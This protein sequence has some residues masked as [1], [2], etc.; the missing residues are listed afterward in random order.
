MVRIFLSYRREDSSGHA[1]HLFE[2]LTSLYGR[3]AVFMDVATLQGGEPFADRIEQAIGQADVFLAL[4]GKRWLEA[5]DESGRRRLDVPE[6]YVRREVAAAL[7]RTMLTIPVRLDGAAMP[8]AEE[9]PPNLKGLTRLNAF[10]LGSAQWDHDLE[11]LLT[12]LPP[13]PRRWIGRFAFAASI[14]VVLLVLAAVLRGLIWPA[15]QPMSGSF[16]VAVLDFGERQSSQAAV[17]TSADGRWIAEQVYDRLRWLDTR[18]EEQGTLV[19]TV[20]VVRLKEHV[21]GR[22]SAEI[23]RSLVELASRINAT[24]LVYGVLELNEPPYRL[25][26]SLYLTEHFNGGEEL[27][28]QSAFGRPLEVTLPLTPG[29][30]NSLALADDLRARLEALYLFTLAVAYLQVDRPQRALDLLQDASDVRGWETGREVLA[31]F[32]GSALAELKRY[33]EAD[34]AYQ[35][36]LALSGNTYARAWIGRGNSFYARK[37]VDRAEGFY[38]QALAAAGESPVAHVDAKAR[39]NLGLALAQ[40]SLKVGEACEAAEARTVL[41]EVVA[42]HGRD[43]EAD[44]LRALAFKARYQLGLL[45]E[46]CAGAPAA[47]SAIEGYREAETQFREALLLAEPAPVPVRSRWAGWLGIG[48]TPRVEQRRWQRDRWIVWK[49]LGYSQLR[50]AE[51]GHSDLYDEAAAS[52]RRVTDH[53]KLKPGDVTPRVAAEAYRYLGRALVQSDPAGAQIALRQADEIA[54]QEPR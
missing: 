38:R 26:P 13:P 37:L 5:R 25:T 23:T 10:E 19:G 34:M 48:D 20:E 2:R 41:A 21:E 36:A 50:L 32:R 8:N 43:P 3:R 51:L 14:V 53:F 44:T 49:Y 4:I 24:I 42:A 33:D 12:L 45:A 18:L 7:A 35:E 6:D 29:G 40:V 22:G 28:G 30:A 15:P 1:R 11:R 17:R 39:F 52:L 47:A 46:G 9:L 27:T 16:N 31:L 54:N